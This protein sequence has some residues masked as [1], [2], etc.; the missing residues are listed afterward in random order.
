MKLRSNFN[1]V[2]VR[3]VDHGWTLA[4]PGS[5]ELKQHPDNC[6]IKM[7]NETLDYQDIVKII[8]SGINNKYNQSPSRAGW[9]L[10]I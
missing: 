2:G 6:R 1:V 3:K 7:D 5:K 9:R 8:Y 10:F 4:K